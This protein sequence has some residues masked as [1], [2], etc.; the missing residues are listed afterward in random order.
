MDS[1]RV[2]LGIGLHYFLTENTESGLTYNG[3]HFISHLPV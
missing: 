1:C 3:I 2:F